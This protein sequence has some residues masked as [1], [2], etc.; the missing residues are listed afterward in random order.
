[1]R[2]NTLFVVAAALF[3]H[4]DTHVPHTKFTVNPIDD[5]GRSGAVNAMPVSSH[6]RQALSKGRAQVRQ[7][8]VI[9]SNPFTR[10]DN[11]E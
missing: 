3:A 10:V 11:M 5:R 4:P 2:L 8:F 6:A 1:M 7:T 9:R